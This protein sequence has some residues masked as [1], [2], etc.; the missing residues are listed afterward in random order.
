MPAKRPNFFVDTNIL[1]DYL[2]SQEYSKNKVKDSQ[3]YDMFKPSIDFLSFYFKNEK[4]LRLCTSFFNL[5]EL[6]NVLIDE[7]VQKKMFRDR[8]SFRY[9]TKYKGIFLKSKNY[10]EQ[11]K[12]TFDDYYA[13]LKEKKIWFINDVSVSSESQLREIDEL[14]V[15]HDLPFAD[16]LIFYVAQMEGGFFV[17]TDRHFLDNKT[18][19]KLY[20]SKIEIVSPSAAIARM[21]LCLSQQVH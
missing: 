1:V 13:F 15:T 5:C 20:E 11:V 8:I 6:P 12:E 4:N 14:H 21:K 10:K 17:T 2:L 3:F 7:L 18:L 9:F 19:K 16:T